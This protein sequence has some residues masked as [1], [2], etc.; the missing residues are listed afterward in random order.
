MQKMHGFCPKLLEIRDKF[1]MSI[2]GR[3]VGAYI[4]HFHE[5]I[6]SWQVKG[7]FGKWWWQFLPH[8][9]VVSLWISRFLAPFPT[10]YHE[11]LG[12]IGNLRLSRI[13]WYVY[14]WA[15]SKT[16]RATLSERQSRCTPASNLAGLIGVIKHRKKHILD[17]FCSWDH[18]NSYFRGPRD[19]KNP[20]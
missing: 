15:R 17:R 18:Q 20:R 14:L 9:N 10:R 5:H 3:L 2:Q 1:G 12:L 7:T 8:Q 11:K 13:R 19:A 6:L 4:T 16:E